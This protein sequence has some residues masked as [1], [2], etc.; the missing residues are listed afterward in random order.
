MKIIP[1]NGMIL[2]KY[3]ARGEATKASGI[4]TPGKTGQ[5][6]T[7]EVVSCR[8]E[9]FDPDWV[10][11]ST[12]RRSATGPDA[13]REKINLIVGQVVM[14]QAHSMRPILDDTDCAEFGFIRWVDVLAIIEE[15]NEDVN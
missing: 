10:E 14:I 6:K 7:M 11:P 13:E 15:E 4:I 3:L 1:Q 2:I 8:V 12:I 9:K 5:P